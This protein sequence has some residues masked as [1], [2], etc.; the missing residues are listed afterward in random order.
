MN[1]NRPFIHDNDAPG[2][3]QI[4]TEA[5]RLFAHKGLS[6]TSIRDIANATGLSNP[7]LYKHF[8]TKDELAHVL[9][10]R[11][12]RS[13]LRSLQKDVG[14]ENG[15]HK[16]FRAFL[17]CRLS[18]YDDQPAATIFASDS[19][20]ALWPHMPKEMKDR[21]IL[22]LLREII[23]LGR[24]EG[25]VGSDTQITMQMAVVI[26]VLEQVTR[27]MFFGTLP[28]PAVSHLEEAEI[29]LGKALR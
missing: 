15:F 22:S 12:Y 27:Q 29:I 26:G 4:L 8:K 13:H 17:Q 14:R 11:L 5:L 2:K 9:F 18:A 23:E 20:M 28:G 25:H 1:S 3:V 24:S 16:R 21:T 6:A 19:F 7:A 10:E